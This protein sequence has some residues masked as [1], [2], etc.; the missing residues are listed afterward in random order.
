MPNHSTAERET[1]APSL[2]AAAARAL[3]ET[4]ANAEFVHGR[5]LDR[6]RR[7]RSAPDAKLLALA[8]LEARR[9]EWRQAYILALAE[10]SKRAAP[11]RS[12]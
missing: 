9:H 11:E 4:L 5:E 3:S 2:E 10:L 8:N 1:S 6:V 7:S 12:A